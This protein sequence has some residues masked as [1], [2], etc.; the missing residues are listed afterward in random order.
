[1]SR[2]AWTG[3]AVL[4]VIPTGCGRSALPATTGDAAAIAGGPATQSPQPDA[5]PEPECTPCGEHLSEQASLGCLCAR[6]HCPPDFDRARSDLRSYAA[7]GTGCDSAWF[8]E[9]FGRGYEVFA[10]RRRSG[11]L[12]YTQYTD[13][14][15]AVACEDGSRQLLLEGGRA[16]QCPRIVWCRFAHV[17]YAIGLGELDSAQTCDERVLRN[18]SVD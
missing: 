5:E 1:M 17:D 8:L 9:R 6:T 15:E 18:K 10:Y 13:G 14:D 4:L 11:A 7:Y 16:P 3:L 2:W 12:V